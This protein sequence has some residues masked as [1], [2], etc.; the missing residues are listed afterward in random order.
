MN[1]ELSLLAQEISD[2]RKKRIN[3]KE[4]TPEPLKLK[5]VKASVEFSPKSVSETC[6]VGVSTMA[7][8]KM[9]FKANGLNFETS[10]LAPFQ[11]PLPHTRIESSPLGRAILQPQLPVK[12]QNPCKAKVG[13]L[14]IEFTDAA[15]LAA[16][17][18]E[19]QNH[20][21]RV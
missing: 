2:W 20:G 9:Q 12:V 1:K 3:P 11:Q 4:G 8:W 5:I 21:R 18:T 19:F 10:K 14:E 16:F 15:F 13:S 7:A 17:V 6:E